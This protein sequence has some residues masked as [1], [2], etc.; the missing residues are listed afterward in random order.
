MTSSLIRG[1]PRRARAH[2]SAR[3]VHALLGTLVGV[4]WLVLPGTAA[5]GAVGGGAHR[6][7]AGALGQRDDRGTHT[8]DLVLPMIA[9]V[10]A[11]AL[12]SFGFWRRRRRTTG[13]TTPGGAP[14]PGGG[15]PDE[16]LDERAQEALV[17]AD[18]WVRVSREELGFAE[19]R[20]EDGAPE[21]IE[22]VR[23]ALREAEAELAAAFRIRWRYEHGVPGDGAARRHAL[24]GVVGR[25]EE[26]GRL[27]DVRAAAFDTLRGLEEGPGGGLGAALAVAEGRFRGL[28][29]RT[30]EADAILRELGDRYAAA[31]SSAVV[32]NVEQAKDRL[33]FATTRLNLARQAADAGE[34]GRAASRL[35]AAEGAIA[36]A[37]VLI[38]GVERLRGD[39][40]TAA[41]LVPAAL[42]GAEA[43]IAGARRALAGETAAHPDVTPGELRARTGHADVVLAG[44]RQELASGRPYDP[45]NLLR[46]IVRAVAPLAA[47]RAGVLPAAAAVCARAAVAGADDVV[48][49]HGAVVGCAAR[50][51]LAE[52][53]RREHAEDPADLVTADT[54]AE[55][56]HDLADQDT[57]LHGHPPEPTPDLTA[58]TVGAL[59]PTPGSYGGPR[60]SAR[61]READEPR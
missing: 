52:A 45:L 50:T 2:I 47:G 14:V 6:P 34:A 28:T 58:A 39:L 59:H 38:D 18:G 51:R 37:G 11:G 60:T 9:V 24:A 32:G 26:V 21:E 40:A 4:V 30:G 13:R 31:A 36:Q 41:E 15:P 17:R 29:A 25:C 3:V 5:G 42:T 55:E 43:E 44:V 8:A 27:L 23:R 46:R 61:R 19:A 56:A 16:E 53:R 1:R 49:T 12:A 57:R 20:F 35:R 10:A 54:L 48:A 22:D 33:V 7:V